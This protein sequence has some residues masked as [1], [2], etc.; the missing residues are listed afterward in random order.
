[1]QLVGR[2]LLLLSHDQGFSEFEM[3]SGRRVADCA[4]FSNVSSAR[5]LA[6]GHTLV[7]YA[8][9]KAPAGVFV[10]E[11]DNGLRTVR[12]TVY[13][14][15]YVRLMRQTARGTF[16]FGMNDKIREGD[17]RGNYVW[18]AAVP[19][20]RHAWKAVRLPNGNTLASAGYGAFLVEMG[21]DGG[22]VRKF[23]SAADVPAAVHP[24]FYA[25]FQLLSNGDV[26]VANWQG[27]GPGH[28]NSGI[29]VLEYD[30]GGAIVWQWS[31]RHLISSVQA[32]LILDGLD[33]ARLHDERNGIMEPIPWIPGDGTTAR[34]ESARRRSRCATRPESRGK[35]KPAGR[36]R[37]T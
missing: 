17:G 23:G 20:F 37:Q 25:T 4:R 22:I 3:T 14:G 21:P 1:L 32:V 16:L 33:T 35:G 29:Q 5:R 34:R 19:G 31:G 2:N 27:H 15:N 18:T 12:T 36:C 8:V 28:G 7:V 11:L 13:P 9:E 10:E 24:Y 30:P 26:V 6:D